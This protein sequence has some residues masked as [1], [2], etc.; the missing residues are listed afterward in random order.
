MILHSVNVQE[1]AISADGLYNYDLAVNP[2]SMVLIALRPLND[3]G[4]LANYTSYRALCAALNRVSITHRGE[5]VINMRGEDIAALNY[6]RWGMLPY[7]GQGDNV[8]NER[9]CCVLPILF[10]RWPYSKTS[11]FPASRRGEL[12]MELDIDIADT[13]YDGMRISVE[14]IEIPDARPVEFE[15]KI[16]S[17]QTW[18]ATGDQDFDLPPGN[19]CRGLFLFGTTAFGGANPAPS[20]GRVKVLL[21]NM[22]QGYAATDF[23]VAQMLHCLWG[24]QAPFDTHS[25]TVNAAGAGVEETTSTFDVGEGYNSYA[26]LDFD[27]MGDD[28]HTLDT[29]GRSRFHVRANAET[30][31]AVR[32]TPLEVVK[33]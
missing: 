29:R 13:G 20:W 32:V 11:C 19:L 31:D 10:G 5:S 27:P 9:R 15:R 22:E 12:N 30:A 26:L 6:Y 21:D 24:R 2:L 18:A 25:H 33:L 3:T 1:Q 8:D 16:T 17:S 28:A 23:E 4:T 14:S 7:Q